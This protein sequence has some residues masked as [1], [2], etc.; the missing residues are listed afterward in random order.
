MAC[1][2]TQS[3]LSVQ[4]GA[5]TSLTTLSQTLEKVFSS[6]MF[7]GK[8]FEAGPILLSLLQTLV[9]DTCHMR[10]R[11]HAIWTD[12]ALSPSNPIYSPSAYLDH[13]HCNDIHTY[14]AV[15]EDTCHM[16]RRI[17]AI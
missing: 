10:R 1:S 9:E 14:T 2:R 5:S 16:R 7:L 11:I 12:T 15:V 13:I 8:E 17:H 3:T 4:K 6:H